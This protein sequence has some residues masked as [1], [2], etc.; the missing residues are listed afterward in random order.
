[1]AEIRKRNEGKSTPGDE[2]VS[3]DKIW[4]K[5]QEAILK[6]W[7]EIGSSYRYMHDRAFSKYSK[8][9][10]WVC[11]LTNMLPMKGFVLREFICCKPSR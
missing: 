7:S 8:Q 11:R 2:E 5:Q 1:M 9:N 3:E 6:R 10:F 4:H